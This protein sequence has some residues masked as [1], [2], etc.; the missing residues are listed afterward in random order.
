MLRVLADVPWS[1]V[2]ESA[3][4]DQADPEIRGDLYDHMLDLYLPLLVIPRVSY[5][6]ASKLLHLN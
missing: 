2:P 4:L 6:K 5:A 1:R 3:Q